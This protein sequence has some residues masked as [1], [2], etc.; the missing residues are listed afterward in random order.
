MF[1]DYVLKDYDENRLM[2]CP[3]PLMAIA[4]SAELM[5]RIAVTAEVG[6]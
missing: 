5:Q 1:N 4:L 2:L 6:F 3:N